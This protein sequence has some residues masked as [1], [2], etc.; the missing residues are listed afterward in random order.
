MQKLARIE[1]PTVA[2]IAACYG[3]WFSLVAFGQDLNPVL[4]IAAAGVLTALYWSI[5]HEVV[6]GHPTK[7]RLVN[8]ALV[9]LPIG[10]VYAHGRFRDGHL[11]HHHT[12]DL[13]DPFDDPE[14]WYLAQH[15][16]KANS[17]VAHA[18]LNF[19]NTLL[20][21]LTVGPLIVFW[22]MVRD[23][24]RAI[25]QGG[26]KGRAVASAW[27]WHVPPV[28]VLVLLVGAITDVRFWEFAAAAYVGVS[29]ILIRTFLEHQ[30]S[31]KEG[32]RT[33]IIEDFG[34][35]AFLFLYNNLHVVHHT[36][37]GLA[38]YRL[39]SFYRR[40]RAQ[41]IKRNNGYVYPSY[42]AIFRKYFLTRKEPVPH[43]F[44]A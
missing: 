44:V 6:H 30:A 39:P 23:D 11:Q 16:W 20:G 43:P 24:G 12:G 35:L 1:W 3:A 41:F 33:V 29:L 7:N 28:F 25:V 18:L 36:R 19:N 42:W 26:E 32:E 15:D 14:S 9:W 31:E 8:H 38:W 5:V 10:W 21:R 40:H 22:R 13:T 27:L 17:S 34:P 4:W 37:P 2:L